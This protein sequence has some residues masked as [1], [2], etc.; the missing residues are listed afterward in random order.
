MLDGDLG[1]GLYRLRKAAVETL[2][3][4]RIFAHGLK[5]DYLNVNAV[6]KQVRDSIEARGMKPVKSTTHEHSGKTVEIRSYPYAVMV[7]KNDTAIVDLLQGIGNTNDISNAAIEQL[8]YNLME[9]LHLLEHKNKISHVAI[10][11]GHNEPNDMFSADLEEVLSEYF[12]VDRGSINGY[13]IDLHILDDYRAI[14]IANPQSRFGE[15]ERFVIDQY[16]MR[17]GSVLWAVDGVTFSEDSLQ[18][19]GST[20]IIPHDIAISDMLF[21]YGIKIH[22]SL[23]QDVQCLS[24]PMQAANSSIYS[25]I[26]IDWTYAPLLQANPYHPISHNLGSVMSSFVSP[27]S[28]VNVEDSIDKIVLLY[29][30]ANSKLTNTPNEV[31]FNDINPDWSTFDKQHIPVG[32]AMEG[33][34]TSAYTYRMAPYGVF[35][36][37]P[38]RKKGAKARQVVIGTGSILM[39]SE[40]RRVGK[41]C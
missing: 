32:V 28:P 14:I 22:P 34:F 33:R 31:N 24:I 26:Q 12:Q 13:G 1:P 17:G 19:N 15:A 16:I 35:T 18:S 3:E 36:N 11:E 5:I 38:I 20:P 8:E 37:E 41:E 4:M 40:E 7:Y 27:I 23:V 9:K 25:D 10:L 6:D 29:S 39:R 2:E 30:S 21:N